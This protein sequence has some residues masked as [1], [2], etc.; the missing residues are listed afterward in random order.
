MFTPIIQKFKSDLD[1]WS[2]H[3]SIDGDDHRL[4]FNLYT[5]AEKAA[6]I[7][8]EIKSND[9][10]SI[11]KNNYLDIDGVDLE[12]LDKDNEANNFNKEIISD[13]ENW[14]K[15]IQKSWPPYIKGVCEMFINLITEVKKNTP[16]QLDKNNVKQIE[17]YYK[18]ISKKIAALWFKYGSHAFLH[19]LGA[20]FGYELIYLQIRAIDEKSKGVIL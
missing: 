4:K 6:E 3:R 15:E 17:E 8:N 16:N 10:Y 7:L 14:P 5:S 11:I 13:V 20:I 19:H 2:F 9:F 18:E 1:C 12:F